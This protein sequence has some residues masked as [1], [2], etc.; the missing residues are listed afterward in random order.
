MTTTISSPC[1]RSQSNRGK[2]Q[3]ILRQTELVRT[4]LVNYEKLVR[5]MPPD[6]R[7]TPQAEQSLDVPMP[8]EHLLNS[9][10]LLI[11]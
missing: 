2:C 6:S 9:S 1:E 3:L 4:D 5:P 7:C 11:A 8:A 10:G